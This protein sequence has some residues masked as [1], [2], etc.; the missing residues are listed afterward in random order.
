MVKSRRY[1]KEETNNPDI[2]TS[3]ELQTSLDS[4]K[5]FEDILEKMSV[6]ST[7]QYSGEDPEEA[8]KRTYKSDER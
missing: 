2:K 6:K 3:R 8:V 1:S 4:K 5:E 7:G